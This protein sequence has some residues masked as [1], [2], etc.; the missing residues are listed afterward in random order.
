MS[1][2]ESR[3]H[4]EKISGTHRRVSLQTGDTFDTGV[5]GTIKTHYKLL[6]EQDLPLPVDYV[7]GA[8]GA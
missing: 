4:V 5:H 2:Y 6:D 8:T 1:F 3:C 7:V